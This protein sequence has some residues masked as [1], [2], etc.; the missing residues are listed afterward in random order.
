M[1]N[2]NVSDTGSGI[3]DKHLQLLFDPFFSTKDVGVGLG[4]GLTISYSIIKT[5]G[6]DLGA[7]NSNEGAVFT[8]RL[9]ART[10]TGPTP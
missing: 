3:D 4:L 10:I 1:A 9:Q 7:R 5:M 6:G 8:I 2:I